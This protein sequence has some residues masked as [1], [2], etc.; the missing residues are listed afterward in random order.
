MAVLKSRQI[1]VVA[2]VLALATLAV[3]ITSHRPSAMFRANVATEGSFVLATGNGATEGSIA[4]TADN[5]ATEG[6]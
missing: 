2:A 1:F 4:V 3:L 5:I 6:S